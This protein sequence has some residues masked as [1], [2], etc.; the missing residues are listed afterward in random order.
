MQIFH[1]EACYLELSQVG[2]G[3]VGPDFPPLYNVSS[4]FGMPAH[5][6]CPVA[7]V[8]SAVD[9]FGGECEAPERSKQR[10]SWLEHPRRRDSSVDAV[11][12]ESLAV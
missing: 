9:H 4:T 6:A 3:N 8:E 7:F 11:Q 2:W 1:H 12:G 10:L 5:G